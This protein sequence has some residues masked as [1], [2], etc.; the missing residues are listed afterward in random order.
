MDLKMSS[1]NRSTF[2]RGLNVV[3]RYNINPFRKLFLL[4]MHFFFFFFNFKYKTSKF[5]T[6]LNAAALYW[7]EIE[8]MKCSI[9][10]NHSTAGPVY[11]REPNLVLIM[12]ADCLAPTV[13][14]G[15]SAH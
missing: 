4:I 9:S 3:T 10:V 6:R 8:N 1:G 14:S 7:L 11:F 5:I 12:P 15:H 13:A 2:D